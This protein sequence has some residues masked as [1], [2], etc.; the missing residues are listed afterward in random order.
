MQYSENLRGRAISSRRDQLY[1][2]LSG[3]NAAAQ[4]EVRGGRS[5]KVIL[6]VRE[7]LGFEDGRDEDIARYISVGL[8]QIVLEDLL[9]ERLDVEDQTEANPSGVGVLTTLAI[10]SFKK[11]SL[12]EIP[13]FLD[14]IIAAEVDSPALGSKG[15]KIGF[16]YW[17]SG[18]SRKIAEFLALYD[19]SIAIENQASQNATRVARESWRQTPILTSPQDAPADYGTPQSRLRASNTYAALSSSAAQTE[20]P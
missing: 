16:L 8:K 19:E 2:I 15:T 10:K 5:G 13:Q 1:D 4:K 7:N 9:Q 12:L 14:H 17:I 3:S 20:S 6:W 18:L 11:L